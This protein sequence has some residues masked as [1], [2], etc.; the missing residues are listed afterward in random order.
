VA[1][2]AAGA[3]RRG[4]TPRVV[5]GTE[6]ATAAAGGT[7]PADLVHLGRREAQGRADLVD[8]QLHHGALLAFLRLEGALPQPALR[9]DPH[10]AGER[11]GHVLR[12]LPPDV[13]AQEQRLAV[14]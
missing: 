5:G 8:L 4:R 6:T 14:L 12:G 2:P 9:H 10:A 3:R 13:A 11:L 1:E 7:T